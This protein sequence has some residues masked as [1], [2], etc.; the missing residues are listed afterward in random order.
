ME[1][2]E[3]RLAKFSGKWKFW[4]MKNE[5]YGFSGNFRKKV[6]KKTSKSEFV[7]LFARHFWYLFSYD[8]CSQWKFSLTLS[9]S[10][11][12]TENGL[13]KLQSMI[14]MSKFHLNWSK[15][16]CGWEDRKLGYSQHC[17]LFLVKR[18]RFWQVFRQ[19]SLSLVVVN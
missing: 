3:H 19:L 17:F 13:E 6:K 2:N 12:S 8:V 14:K 15:L 5:F 18:I 11:L 9:W 7:L 16:S 10:Q 1:W 4:K